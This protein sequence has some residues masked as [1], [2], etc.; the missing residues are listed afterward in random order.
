MPCRGMKPTRHEKE[1]S[2]R[3]AP[4][5][6]ETYRERLIM[7]ALVIL[8]KLHET[9]AG[10]VPPSAA[11][12]RRAPAATSRHDNDDDIALSYADPRLCATTGTE[13]TLGSIE[14]QYSIHAH[15]TRFANRIVKAETLLHRRLDDGPLSKPLR[16]WPDISESQ[17]Y[18]AKAASSTEFIARLAAVSGVRR[19]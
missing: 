6:R 7:L 19:G 13:R 18:S 15:R 5:S 2:G 1:E 8:S 3:K 16:S 10:E 17:P 12:A 11:E 14:N 9:V 4:S